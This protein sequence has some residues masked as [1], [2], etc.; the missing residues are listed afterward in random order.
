MRPL[1]SDLHLNRFGKRT[2][3]AQHRPLGTH[4]FR[5]QGEKENLATAAAT[6]FESNPKK[7][8]PQKSLE[9]GASARFVEEN[10][11]VKMN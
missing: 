6:P 7:T 4:L 8:H 5:F 1:I 11:N 3:R 9:R 10:V 2:V